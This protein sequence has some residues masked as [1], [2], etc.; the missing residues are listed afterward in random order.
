MSLVS[1][2][3]QKLRTFSFSFQREGFSKFNKIY[4]YDYQ[5]FGQVEFPFILL[6]QVQNTN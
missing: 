3:S 5:M 6:L 1:C 4:E 2:S